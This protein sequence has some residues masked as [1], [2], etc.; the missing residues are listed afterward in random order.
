MIYNGFAI[1]SYTKM[2]ASLHASEASA[3]YNITKHK[4]RFDMNIKSVLFFVAQ[5][6]NKIGADLIICTKRDKM[7]NR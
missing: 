3:S 6:E 1:D 5:T 2:N 7:M 4:N